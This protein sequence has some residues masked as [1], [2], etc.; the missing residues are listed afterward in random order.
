[1]LLFFFICA[2]V[3][4]YVTFVLSLFDPFLFLLVPREGCA[5]DYGYYIL[6]LSRTH[7]SRITANLEV[8]IF[9]LPKHENLTISKTIVEK[10]RGAIFFSTI[11]SIYL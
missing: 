6:W 7:F 8:K 4:S 9:S 1:M 3:V 5:H 10:R 2:S 11:F